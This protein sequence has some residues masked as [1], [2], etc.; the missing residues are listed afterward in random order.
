M[1]C[2]RREFLGVLAGG[3]V[4]LATARVRAGDPPA[5][6]FFERVPLGRHDDSPIALIGQGGNVMVMRAGA[7]TLVVDCKVAPFGAVLRQDVST[8]GADPSKTLVV[9]THHHADHTGGNHAFGGVEAIL[10]HEKAAPRIADQ[11]DQYVGAAAGAL[12]N[13][14]ELAPARRALALPGVER[15]VAEAENLD[16]GD[17]APTKVIT[18]DETRIGVGGVALEL[19]HFGPGHTD[20]DLVLRLPDLNIVHTGDL[21]FN[22]MNP[23]FDLPSGASGLG[24][25]ESCARVI[26]LC[27]EQTV[28]VP[29]HGPITDVGGIRTQRRYFERLFERVRTEIDK[30][31]PKDDITQMSWA[32][33]EGLEYPRLGVKAIGSA[34]DELTDGG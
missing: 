34:Y 19:F 8:L 12:G 24:W 9:N 28:V 23:Y 4:V 14:K 5:R 3:A 20:N 30:G 10:A 29:G 33:T 6:L 1:P 18:K 13:V 31:T 25:I 17:F 7:E 32:F 26:E 22:Q 15:F 2:D 21:V 16:A 27:D 11:L